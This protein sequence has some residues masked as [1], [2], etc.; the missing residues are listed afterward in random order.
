MGCQSIKNNLAAIHLISLKASYF[1][2]LISSP[3]LESATITLYIDWAKVQTVASSTWP[4]SVP[5]ITLPV[6][7]LPSPDYPVTCWQRNEPS[8]F[9]K[10]AFGSRTGKLHSSTSAK[11]WHINKPLSKDLNYKPANYDTRSP[12]FLFF[13]SLSWHRSKEETF[14]SLQY[15]VFY[16]HLVNRWC[17]I[18]LSE[19]K[20]FIFFKFS[21]P[22]KITCLNDI[23]SAIPNN[24][25]HTK[26]QYIFS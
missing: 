19:P 14:Y 18:E 21:M 10:S 16:E 8:V 23:T 25:Q 3:S 20:I 15:Y 12:F 26:T 9:W 2:L 13:F 17:Q 6:Q 11:N 5:K 4:P 1:L 7:D 24:R 22:T